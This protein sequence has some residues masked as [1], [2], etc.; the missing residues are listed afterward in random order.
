MAGQLAQQIAQMKKEMSMGQLSSGGSASSGWGL[1]TSPYAVTPQEAPHGAP[2]E[3]GA[4]KR[5][6]DKTLGNTAATK[7]EPLYSPEE[8]AHGFSSENQLHGQFDL[9][10]PPQK[11]E[12][13]RSAPESQAALT[14][15]SNIIGSYANGE[16][17]AVSREQVP[18]EYQ[19]LVKEYFERLQQE[20]A[21]AKK[22]GK[23]A[24]SGDEKGKKK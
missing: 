4:G 15:Y 2:N 13:V 10:Q 18:L 12:D 8:F 1:G 22:D 21:A 7:Y 5:E 24:K 11:I 23:G 3:P 17:S 20:A 6:G 9:S 16:E 14:E 19:E